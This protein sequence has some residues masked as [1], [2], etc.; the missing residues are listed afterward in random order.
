ML[1]QCNISYKFRR[2]TLKTTYRFLKSLR[3]SLNVQ[4]SSQQN[5]IIQKYRYAHHA[6]C[7]LISVIAWVTLKTDE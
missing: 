2:E 1:A 3:C 6:D 4:G 7:S 5:I